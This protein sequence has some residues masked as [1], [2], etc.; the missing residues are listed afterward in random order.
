[1]HLICSTSIKFISS[2]FMPNQRK[3][4]CDK[5]NIAMSCCY[6]IVVVAYIS[7]CQQG[8]FWDTVQLGSKHAHWY[9]EQDFQYFLLPNELDSGHPPIFGL[10]LATCWKIFGYSLVVSHFTILPFTVGSLYL[11]QRIGDYFLG[12][13]KGVL[14]VI[15]MMADPTF[16]AQNLL[17]S[18]DACLLFFLFFGVY[19]LIHHKKICLAIAAIGLAAIS[20]RGMMVVVVLYVALIYLYTIRN[21][22]HFLANCWKAAMPF[23]PSGLLAV[24]F[25]AYHYLEVGWI[26]YH[27]DSPWQESFV[28]VD[29]KG[30]LRNI[31]IYG[32]RL[33]DFG[34][35]GGLILLL[36]L[37]FQ[38]K[39]RLLQKI[40]IDKKLQ[41]IIIL[42]IASFVLLSPSLLLYRYLSAHRYLLPIIF[43][44]HLLTLYLLMQWTN[45]KRRRI[46]YWLWIAC[47]VLGNFWIY[48]PSIAQG[49]DASLAFLPYDGQRKEM[50][51][52]IWQEDIP[53]SSIGSV[54][55]EVGARKYR[56][57]NRVEEGFEQ[58]D[59]TKH[60]Y[61]FYANVM[62]DFTDAE[63][64]ELAQQWRVVKKLR[65]GGVVVILYTR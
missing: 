16:A 14:L 24:A 50:L 54:F 62:N 42:L 11:L 51:Q 22:Q 61:I 48:P 4:L 36:Y 34:R 32:W 40:L 20:M 31:A 3:L 7:V 21:E 9:L 29:A 12:E 55:P 28:R 27:D 45:G 39:N 25:L 23:V 46:G 30:L 60:N 64:L 18:P 35:I 5:A 56:E 6:L 65:Q 59:L 53:L 15:L 58:A 38:S 8:F 37:V 2:F 43:L 19:G 41:L 10:Y 49:W 26:G 63:R 1:M 17:I 52:F 57:L 44:I 13:K 33:A 47:L